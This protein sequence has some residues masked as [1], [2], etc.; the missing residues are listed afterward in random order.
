MCV[1][2]GADAG[3]RPQLVEAAGKLGE[4]LARADTGFDPGPGT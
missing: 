1:F 4:E 3:N 2:C